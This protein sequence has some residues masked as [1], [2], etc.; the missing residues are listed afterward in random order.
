M[1]T[2]KRGVLGPMGRN[3]TLK[4]LGPNNGFIFKAAELLLENKPSHPWILLCVDKNIR[5]QIE[6]KVK[7]I[8]QMSPTKKQSYIAKILGQFVNAQGKSSSRGGSRQSGGMG[9]IALISVIVSVGIAITYESINTNQTEIEHMGI[10]YSK[11][12]STSSV[13]IFASDSDFVNREFIQDI[14]LTKFHHAA[15]IAKLTATGK[16]FFE[17]RKLHIYLGLLNNTNI[18]TNFKAPTNFLPYHTSSKTSQTSYE[19]AK[20]GIQDVVKYN[21]KVFDP[22]TF[23]DEVREKL[24]GPVTIIDKSRLKVVENWISILKYHNKITDDIDLDIVPFAI[25]V[26]DEKYNDMPDESK[27]QG[28]A[29]FAVK[30]HEH[31]KKTGL[32]SEVDR[33]I[34]ET[35]YKAAKDSSTSASTEKVLYF[36]CLYFAVLFVLSYLD[37]KYSFV[38]TIET[39][40]QSKILK[41]KPSRS[42]LAKE[43]LAK[44]LGVDKYDSS[45]EAETSDN[46]TVLS[47][48]SKVKTG[49]HKN[50]EGTS[51]VNTTLLNA[52]V[53][54]IDLGEKMGFTEFGTSKGRKS[55][56]KG[57]NS[58]S[59]KRKPPANDTLK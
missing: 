59:K 51:T 2:L 8:N 28:A 12:V 27:L 13:T 58:P 9:I 31:N 16:H 22:K 54:T 17:A 30:L 20:V 29:I 5:E 44:R 18:F 49:T 41:K 40:I 43:E 6:K 46:K 32:T 39:I 57:R 52:A 3:I 19:I 55:P 4:N 33:Q 42:T 24:S 50:N 37:G 15:E 48:L 1:L 10:R 23:V 34:L 47:Q 21:D 11:A 45:E 25:A 38:S 53:N 35:T 26:F 56:A 7:E 36:L 14:D